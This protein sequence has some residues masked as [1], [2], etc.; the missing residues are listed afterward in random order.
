MCDKILNIFLNLKRYFV[1][2]NIITFIL[3]TNL[4]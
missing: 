4:F 1:L 3:K 2:N